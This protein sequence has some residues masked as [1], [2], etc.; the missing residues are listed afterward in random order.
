MGVSVLG[1]ANDVVSVRRPAAWLGTAAETAR[2]ATSC[3][4][5][6]MWKSPQDLGVDD[7]ISRV[8]EA[9]DI[10]K[11]SLA[12]PSYQFGIS[13]SNLAAYYSFGYALTV[14]SMDTSTRTSEPS[15]KG[16]S[17]RGA[18]DVSGNSHHLLFDSD[19]PIWKYSTAPLAVN[20]L[21]VAGPTA[22]AAGYALSLNDRQVLSMS[23]FHDFPATAL[24][25]EFWM[26]S[27]DKCRQ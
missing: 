7:Y 16:S 27:V 19:S 23:G 9:G 24:T 5:D 1:W 6:N 20:G 14:P 4:S 17:V 25:L 10:Y 12:P 11:D 18:F 15:V 22:G 21:P 26:W 8:Q 3:L 2:W 13:T